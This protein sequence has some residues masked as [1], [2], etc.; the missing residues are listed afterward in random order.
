MPSSDGW[1]TLRQ[2][3]QTASCPSSC[4]PPRRKGQRPQ[5]V[6]WGDDY[7]GKPFS[8]AQLRRGFAPSGQN[9]RPVRHDTHVIT[10]GDLAVD[11]RRIAS[12]A[13]ASRS[14]SRRRVSPPRNPRGAAQQGPRPDRQ[15][16]L[17]RNCRLPVTMS[18]A[19]SG[20]CARSWKLTRTIRPHRNERNIG[21]YFAATSD[22]GAT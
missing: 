16:R 6:R 5:G 14:S 19:T 21:Y 4:S 3:R 12:F 17:G 15:A 18:V 11:P 7:V 2:I 8:F 9:R 10:H 13:A 1:D 22:P 20:T